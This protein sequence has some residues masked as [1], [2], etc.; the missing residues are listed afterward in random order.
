MAPSDVTVDRSRLESRADTLS[1]MMFLFPVFIPATMYYGFR[2]RDRGN[3]FA[4]VALGRSLGAVIW[5]LFLL[6]YAQVL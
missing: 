6:W 4:R 2:L 1:L 3:A 5:T